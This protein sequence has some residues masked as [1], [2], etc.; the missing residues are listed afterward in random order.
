MTQR[1]PELPWR[2]I[3]W[4]VA[5]LA[6]IVWVVAGFTSAGANGLSE[7]ISPRSGFS[8]ELQ[9]LQFQPNWLSVAVQQF[10]LLPP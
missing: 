10:G 1:S 8:T 5:S 9:K 2:L 6:D 4:V 3:A 7:L